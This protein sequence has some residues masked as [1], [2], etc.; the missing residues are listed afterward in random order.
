MDG[1]Q[2]TSDMYTLYYD[3]EAVSYHSRIRT[4]G[5][6]EYVD[7]YVDIAKYFDENTYRSDLWFFGL[8]ERRGSGDYLAPIG[9]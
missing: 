5:D 1:K 4:D 3:S 7:V 6:T 8:G 2:I 9:R